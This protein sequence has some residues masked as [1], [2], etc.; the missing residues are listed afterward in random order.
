MET[1]NWIEW[2]ERYGAVVIACLVL[3]QIIAVWITVSDKQRAKTKRPRI[4]ERKLLLVACL[5]GAPAMLLT[6]LLIRHKTRHAKFMIGLPLIIGAQAL[7]VLLI[8]S[9]LKGS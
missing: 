4:R 7:L 5:G 1:V 3:W 9:Q 8:W 6:M 2:I